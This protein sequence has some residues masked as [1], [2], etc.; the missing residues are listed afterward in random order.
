MESFSKDFPEGA[1]TFV[2]HCLS[3]GDG[4]F[5]SASEKQGSLFSLLRFEVLSSGS[6]LES[7]RFSGLSS[8][9]LPPSSSVLFPLEGT[10]LAPCSF[11]QSDSVCHKLCT[12]WGYT[13]RI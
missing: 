7:L 9:F 11:Q 6:E 13:S 10:F 8:F 3:K 2:S 4:T 12:F 5:V 1:G